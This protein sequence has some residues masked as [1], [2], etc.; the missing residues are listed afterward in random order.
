MA[1]KHGQQKRALAN[2][3]VHKNGQVPVLKGAEKDHKENEKSIKMRPIVNAMDG[4][5]KN[6]SDL[7]SDI[8]TPVIASKKNDI[9]CY[10]T[11]ELLESF[12]NYNNRRV[13]SNDES[14]SEYIIGSMD[15]TSLYPSL[16]ADKSAAIVIE[17]VMNSNVVFEN[18]DI[19]ELGM[20]LRKHLPQ[21]YIKE[22]GIDEM[23]PIR[24]S[25]RQKVN[26]KDKKNNEDED[27]K[28]QFVESVRT[29]Y[30][31]DVDDEQIVDVDD[32][33]IVI[34]EIPYDNHE[35]LVEDQNVVCTSH[36]F[37]LNKSN[38]ED[39]E[40][41]EGIHEENNAMDTSNKSKK[42]NKTNKN[43]N[44]IEEE[45]H[46]E[47]NQ[48]EV[49]SMRTS[50]KRVNSKLEGLCEEKD[51][52]ETSNTNKNKN[53]NSKNKKEKKNNSFW[54]HVERK[55]NE[56]ETKLLVAECLGV[57][58]KIIMSHHIYNFGGQTFLQREHGCI[59]DEAIGV[60]ATIVMIWWSRQFR[61]KLN[62]LQIKNPLTKIYV[63][64]VN[65]VFGSI[66][67]GSEYKDGKLRYNEE[68]AKA[69]ESL[70]ND[71]VTMEIVKEVANSISSMIKMTVDFPS[72]HAD[73][74]VPM[75]DVKVWLNQKDENKI[76]YTFF[77]KPTKSPFVMSKSSA[78]PITKKIECLGQEVFRRLHNMKKELEEE[79][80]TKVLNDFMIKLKISGYN[81][82]DRL[83]ILKSGI[84]AYE[85]LR[86]KEEDGKRPFF[87]SREYNATER[88][89][90][91]KDKKTNWFKKSKTNNQYSSV[92]FVPST[93]G[94]T[95]LR[96]LKETEEKHKIGDSSRIKFVET[97][98]RKYI[99]QLR[100]N[101]PFEEKCKPEEKCMVCMTNDK[102]TNC[103]ITN[104]GYSLI[105]TLCKERGKERTYEGESSR[106]TYLR[107]REHL[108]E[109]EKK[110][111][112]SVMYKHVM[113]EHE[114]E[115]DEVKFQMK[116]VGRFKNPLNR[117]IDESV[118]IQRKNPSSL[119]N[120]KSEFHGPA[121]RRKV[122]E[123]RKRN[124]G[125]T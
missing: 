78:M 96:M 15:A 12:E 1:L 90:E 58:C 104:V 97:S 111:E 17:E 52:T 24:I 83:Q 115:E 26:N 11:E 62:E 121:I 69:D 109:Y 80:K 57:L 82:Y 35:K 105:C 4:P 50:N 41:N 13:D 117:L 119:L 10:S 34:V 94:S 86:S 3:T 88:K 106:N 31:E 75:L 79:E 51:A 74:K 71:K 28:Y 16:E 30:N 113:K 21:K 37:T 124:P 18:I 66:C 9:I 22:K 44:E 114:R 100:V 95:L 68:K 65:G 20:Y 5:K 103:K 70:S 89:R 107:G 99:D 101:D 33:E 39:D 32:D 54:K 19:K 91:K 98:G 125:N 123:G 43:K 116:V 63:D 46:E 8:V 102:T 93:P 77:E 108:R 120:S 85:N 40:E 67:P 72:N 36:D 118:R 59:G 81:E 122:L 55:I 6:I 92:F 45:S 87:R 47:M 42:T 38:M 112:N 23:L 64:D 73:L 48:N 49:H 7:F 27:D 2:A 76:Y 14:S 110:T 29:L 60:I 25:G 53:Y 84:N 56:K 61:L